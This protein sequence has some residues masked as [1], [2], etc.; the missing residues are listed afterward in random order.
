[1]A[2]PH[3]YVP[4]LDLAENPHSID[5]CDTAVVLSFCCCF[6]GQIDLPTTT[7]LKAAL[8]WQKNQFVRN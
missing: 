6:D 7:A 4:D 8:P 2:F 3:V 5:N 1:M